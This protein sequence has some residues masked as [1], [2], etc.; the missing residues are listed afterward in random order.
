MNCEGSIAKASPTLVFK[1][2][3]Y[4]LLFMKCAVKR[5]NNGGKSIRTLR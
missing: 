2:I 4:C 3:V 5:S 1:F